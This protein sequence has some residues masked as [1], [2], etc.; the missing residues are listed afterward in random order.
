MFRMKFMGWSEEGL[1][2]VQNIKKA[3]LLKLNITQKYLQVHIFWFFPKYLYKTPYPY[4]AGWI[5]KY[6]EKPERKGL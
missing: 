2:G 4:Y 6:Q 3:L 5:S 1:N